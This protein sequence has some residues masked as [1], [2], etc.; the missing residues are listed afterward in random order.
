MSHND[1]LRPQAEANFN[2][3]GYFV[4]QPPAPKYATGSGLESELEG[5]MKRISVLSKFDIRMI[6]HLRK[7]CGNFQ[8]GIKTVP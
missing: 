5:G 6:H 3:F 2:G 7:A 8:V 1:K 4:S